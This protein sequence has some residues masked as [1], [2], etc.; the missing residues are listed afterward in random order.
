MSSYNKT[1]F[2]FSVR[3]MA[4]KHGVNN[5][6]LMR[7]LRKGMSLKEAIEA[8]N[9]RRYEYDGKMWELSELAR[10][11]GIKAPTLSDRIH[12]QGM[13][14]QEAVTKP[15]KLK[16]PV[17]VRS[18]TPGYQAWV[19]MRNRCHNPKQLSYQNYGARGIEVCDRWIES[20][21]NFIEDMG[22][23]GEGQSLG[24]ID[25]EGNYCPENCRW[26]DAVTQ[27]SNKRNTRNITAF[28]KTQTAAKWGRE[29]G[30]KSST[31]VKRI[32]VWGYSPEEAVTIPSRRTGQ[33]GLPRK[34]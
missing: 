1:E 2:D 14:I 21:E 22:C 33:G 7:R 5:N 8:G 26:E 24:R 4:R 25:N 31:I 9:I 27:A 10:H 15:V 32:D 29:T 23:P 19:G 34:S 3:E 30:L 17:A 16:P 18:K 11:V 12:L 13:D 6:T 28:G 20:F